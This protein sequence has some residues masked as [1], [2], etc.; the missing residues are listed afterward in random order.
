MY[1]LSYFWLIYIWFAFVVYLV[2]YQNCF[3]Y[4]FSFEMYFST[5]NL[6]PDTIYLYDFLVVFFSFLGCDISTRSIVYDVEI[7]CQ[8]LCI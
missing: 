2:D 5:Q 4:I 8:K 7:Q 3:P 1:I 6:V